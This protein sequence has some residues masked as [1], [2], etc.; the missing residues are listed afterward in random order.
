MVNATGGL[1]EHVG[2]GM[3]P[4]GMVAVLV[5]DGAVVDYTPLTPQTTNIGD[6]G[7]HHAA[8]TLNATVVGSQ[9]VVGL[10]DGDTGALVAVLGALRP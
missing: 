6:V 2:P 1:P 7:V 5:V 8:A 3:A 9:A 4:D 10:Y